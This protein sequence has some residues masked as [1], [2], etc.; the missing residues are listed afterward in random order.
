MRKKAVDQWWLASELL[1]LLR[2]VVSHCVRIG[3]RV[4]VSEQIEPRWHVLAR[5]LQ[6]CVG[7]FKV[8]SWWHFYPILVG[9]F[10]MILS[11]MSPKYY[12]LRIFLK[13]IKRAKK[14]EVTQEG[15]ISL[16]RHSDSRNLLCIG[17]LHFLSYMVYIKMIFPPLSK[18]YR[19]YRKKAIVLLNPIKMGF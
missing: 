1:A 14:L 10:K 17:L 2:C 4:Q 3:Q 12:M 7:D 19:R 15:T 18:I 6:V 5:C 8:L 9:L 13:L 11:I 16:L